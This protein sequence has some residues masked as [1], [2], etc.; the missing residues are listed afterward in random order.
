MTNHRTTRVMVAN[1]CQNERVTMINHNNNMSGVILIAL[2]LNIFSDLLKLLSGFKS[3]EL[4]FG[5]FIS[6]HKGIKIWRP[7]QRAHKQ[8]L[9]SQ[10]KAF[11]LHYLQVDTSESAKRMIIGRTLLLDSSSQVRKWVCRGDKLLLLTSEPHCQ[12]LTAVLSCHCTGLELK[13]LY[14]TYFHDCS[15]EKEK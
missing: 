4:S 11:I 13:L 2:A 15:M 14:S 7:L 8:L 5:I 9:C 10:N 3:H 12:T 6:R 1:D